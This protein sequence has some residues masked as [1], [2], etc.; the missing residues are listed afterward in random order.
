[1]ACVY[2]IAVCVVFG[3]TLSKQEQKSEVRPYGRALFLPKF[4]H[5]NCAIKILKCAIDIG[6]YYGRMKELRATG[7]LTNTLENEVLLCR[8]AL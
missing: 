2:L 5:K 8:K 3:L 1:M 6:R 4:P 7:V